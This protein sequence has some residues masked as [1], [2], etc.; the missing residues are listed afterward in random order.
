M[1]VLWW[2]DLGFAGYG[3]VLVARAE[4]IEGNPHLVRE[5]VAVTQRA[6]AQCLAHAAPCIDALLAEHPQ[7]DRQ[8]E[9]AVWELLASLYRSSPD[10]L[11]PLG[12]FDPARVAAT[13]RD[14]DAAFATHSVDRGGADNAFLD[15][16]IRRTALKLRVRVSAQCQI[17]LALRL[18]FAP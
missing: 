8:R 11:G 6:W 16:T 13:L 17:F 14:L 18:R 12:A 15:P 4:L 1:R 9:L 10:P 2:H 5:F 7:L 3:Q